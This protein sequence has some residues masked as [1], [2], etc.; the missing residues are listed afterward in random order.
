MNY[1]FRNIH[2][3]T[4]FLYY[5]F[6]FAIIML[7]QHPF[8]LIFSSILTVFLNFV[9][10][11]GRTLKNWGKFV[12]FL[13][14]LFIVITPL[15]NH[16]GSVILFYAFQNPITLEA[17]LQGFINALTLFSVVALFFTFSLVIDGE[18]FLFLFS[19][20]LPGWTL[21]TMV[22]VR[23]V[24]L[25]K[26]RLEEIRTVHQTKHS[27]QKHSILTRLKH[28]LFL[29][30]ILLTWSLEDGI[31]TADSMAAR[32]YGLQKRSRYVRYKF[33]K[34]DIFLVGW[35]SLL[36]GIS[37]WGWFLGDGVLTLFPVIEPLLLEGREWFFFTNFLLLVGLPLLIEGKDALQWQFW[38]R[39]N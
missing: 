1:G 15:F 4:N 16:R 32:G 23:F 39:D 12:L 29:V 8:F 6:S 28:G 10:D 3:L 22:S 30:Q 26:R 18:K 35:M 20:H 36:T 37:I 19:K 31:Q 11:A 5:V 17:I 21:L 2:P 27:A 9:L 33:E 38:K 7:N 25:L 14:L 13:I 34:Q 24:P